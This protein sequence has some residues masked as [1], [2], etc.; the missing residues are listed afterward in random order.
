MTPLEKKISDLYDQ[1][2]SQEEA[3]AAA[4]RLIGFFKV[5]WE[6]DRTSKKAPSAAPAR[7]AG[8]STQRRS[9]SA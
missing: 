7:S 9:R 3:T 6:I 2:L 8:G 1:P 4:N 5:L